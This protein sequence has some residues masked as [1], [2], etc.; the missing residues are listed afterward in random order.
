M[1]VFFPNLEK[2]Y[3]YN[4]T[5]NIENWTYSPMDAHVNK[6]LVYI[7]R[8]VKTKTN[9]RSTCQLYTSNLKNI[10]SKF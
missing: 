6:M 1:A 8:E 7:Y 3:G 9:L 2:H 4:Y 10:P 5:L